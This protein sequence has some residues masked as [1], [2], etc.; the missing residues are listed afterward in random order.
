MRL[1]NFGVALTL[2]AAL[3][4]VSSLAGEYRRDSK[5]H[6][7]AAAGMQAIDVSP[8]NGAPGDGWQY[9]SDARKSRAVVISPTGDYYYSQGRGLQLVFKSKPAA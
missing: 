3:M 6:R 5:E 8:E 2:A 7:H 1:G 9:F 4:G